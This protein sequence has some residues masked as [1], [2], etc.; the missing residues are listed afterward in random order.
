MGVQP[1]YIDNAAGVERAKASGSEAVEPQAKR[2]K[3]SVPCTLVH[4]SAASQQRRFWSLLAA[5]VTGRRPSGRA[6]RCK[7]A[8]RTKPLLINSP[9]LLFSPNTANLHYR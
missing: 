1:P 2:C 3:D 5:K 9:H 8:T 6:S 7:S 4:G